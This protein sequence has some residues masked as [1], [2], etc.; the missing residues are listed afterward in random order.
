MKIEK[1]ESNIK[2][3]VQHET[4]IEILQEEEMAK[5]RKLKL[6]GGRLDKINVKWIKA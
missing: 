5:I 1:I 6:R 2:T 4:R 3:G